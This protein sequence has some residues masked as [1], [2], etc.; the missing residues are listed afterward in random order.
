GLT[1][2]L[3]DAAYRERADALDDGL[4][5]AVVE[6]GGHA[7]EGVTLGDGILALFGSARR[8]IECASEVHAAAAMLGL[9]LHVGLHAG[10]VTWSGS[11]VFGGAVNI[12]ARVCDAAPPAQTLVSDTVRSLARTSSG[13]TFVDHGLHDLK[14]IPD[15]HQLFAV[16]SSVPD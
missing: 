12:A 3:G 13:V 11:R 16:T 6:C 8:A 5:A 14:G 10:D 9:E 2:R 15:A 1:E 4:R 7:V